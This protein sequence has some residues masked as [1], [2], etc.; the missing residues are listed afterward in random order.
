MSSAAAINGPTVVPS[1][2]MFSIS[3]VRSCVINELKRKTGRIPDFVA[4]V[5]NAVAEGVAMTHPAPRRQG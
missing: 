1:L 3:F 2:R 4:A 5:K